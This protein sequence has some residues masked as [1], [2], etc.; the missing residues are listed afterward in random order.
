MT[1]LMPPA[2]PRTEWLCFPAGHP[3]DA[4]YCRHAG[5]QAGFLALEEVQRANGGLNDDQRLRL[6]DMR[7]LTPAATR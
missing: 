7:R 6:D 5:R 1:R 2:M 4:A 3:A